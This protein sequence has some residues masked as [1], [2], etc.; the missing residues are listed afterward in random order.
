MDALATWLRPIDW[1]WFLTVTFSWNVRSETAVQRL[2]SFINDL[3][4][5]CRANVGFVAGQESR[6]RRDGMN[7][8]SHFHMLMTSNI[9]I[10][11][12]ALEDLWL[13]QLPSGLTLKQKRESV[14]V[15]PYQA[16]ERGPEYCLKAMN[17]PQG[18]WWIHRLEGF[19]PGA[20]GPSKPNH[21]SVRGARR[22][23]EQAARAH[24]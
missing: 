22:N 21:A 16:L 17:D 2:K 19:L 20:A 9:R 6:T 18:D 3:E 15:E 4:R 23:R 13:R 10:P 5:F 24:Q 1:Q 14:R 12:E 8:P 11:R 7:V